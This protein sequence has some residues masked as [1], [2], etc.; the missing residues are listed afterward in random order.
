MTDETSNNIPLFEN[1][2][3]SVFQIPYGDNLLYTV[4]QPRGGQGATV[5]VIRPPQTDNGESQIL[6]LSQARPPIGGSSWEIPAGGID[7]GEHPHEGA[8]R[9]LREE[10]GIQ[11]QAEDLIFLGNFNSSPTLAK[12]IVHVFAYILPEDHDLESVVIQEDEIDDYKWLTPKELLEE[13]LNNMN[14]SVTIPY[15]LGK[16]RQKN[17]IEKINI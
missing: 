11:A 8:A 4:V 14:V 17:L 12:D 16:L 3:V 9:E 6:L 5:A 2:F 15:I 1:K 10:T 7:F 13:S